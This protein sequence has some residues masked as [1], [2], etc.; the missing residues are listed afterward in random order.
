MK[1]KQLAR[2]LHPRYVRHHRTGFCPVC[3]RHT[4]FCF[5]DRIELVRNHAVCIRCRSISRNRQVALCAIE[6]HRADGIA[7]LADFRKATNLRVLNASSA[8]PIARA[9]GRAPHIHNTEYFEGCPSG[10][11][12]DGIA[13]QDFE[14]LSFASG[15]LDLILSEDVFEHVKDVRRGLA[16][17]GRVLKPGGR[18]IFT[19]PF[20]FD[21][22]TRHLFEKRGDDY[23]P[24]V[25]PV[26]YHGDGIRDRIPAY[27]HLGYDL[28]DWLAQ[29]GMETRVRFADY[30]E[31]RTYGTFNCFTFVS[32]KS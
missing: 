1:F 21:Q 15:S 24:V 27:H 28:F 32:R 8:T 11:V 17:V 30:A 12:K 5:T 26:E 3:A 16:E 10:S 20:H 14:S 2:L 29:L 6:A 25:L 23:V 31:C 22:R 19:V 7:A 18:H 9:L 4:L 13:C